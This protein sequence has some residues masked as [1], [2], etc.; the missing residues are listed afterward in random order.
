MNLT[1]IDLP[2]LKLLMRRIIETRHTTERAETFHLFRAQ[3]LRHIELGDAVVL[4]PVRFYLDRLSRLPCGSE[5]WLDIFR[6][7][8]HTLEAHTVEAV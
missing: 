5:P 2:A 4:K 7:L 1:D 6:A 3:L 8:Q